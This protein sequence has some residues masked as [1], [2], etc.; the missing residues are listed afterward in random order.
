MTERQEYR[1]IMRGFKE[2][3][4]TEEFREYW[5]EISDFEK[6]LVVT[7]GDYQETNIL[8]LKSPRKGSESG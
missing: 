1:D 5:R 8:L 3:V 2:K 6:D 4:L 7:G